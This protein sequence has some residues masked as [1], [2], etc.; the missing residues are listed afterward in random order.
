[1]GQHHPGAADPDRAGARGDGGNQDL[2]RGADNAAVVVVLGK[3]EALIAE[4]FAV[5]RERQGV[6]DGFAMRTINEGN[7]LIEHRQT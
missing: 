5:L 2:R 6:G 1:V 3:P 7:R 4:G